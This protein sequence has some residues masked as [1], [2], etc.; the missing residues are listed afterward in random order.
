[1]THFVIQLKFI[2]KFNWDKIQNVTT[3][4]CENLIVD[5]TCDVTNPKMRQKLNNNQT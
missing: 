5:K 1:M 3:Q 2:Q 4:N